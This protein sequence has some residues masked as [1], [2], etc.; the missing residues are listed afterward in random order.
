MTA[1]VQPAGTVTL[2]FTDI[3]G[4]TRLLEE[5][6][7]EGYRAALAEHRRI[8]REACSRY[9]GYEVDTEGDSFFYAFGSAQAAVGAVSDAMQGL[10]GGPVRVRV[11]IH[12]GEPA[13]DPPNYVGMDVHRAARIMSAAHGGQVVLS[14]STVALLEP[15]SFALEELGAHRLKDLS[16]P[17]VLYQLRVEGLAAVFPPLRTLH[18]S[19]LP[20]PTTPFRGRTDELAQVA[21]RLAHPDT[22]LLTLTGPGGTG[23]TRLALQAAAEAADSYPD[24]VIWVPLAPVRDA[25]LLIVAVAEALQLREQP[26]RTFVETIAQA[27]AGRRTLLLLDNV[28]HLLPSAARDVAGLLE[29]C[30]TLR[31]LVTSRERVRVRA[32]I[33]WSVPP[34]TASDGERLFVERAQAVGVEVGRDET[35]AALCRRLD[36]LPLAIELAAARTR[37]MSPAA[38][39]ARLEE[40]FDLLA[41]RDHDVD[42]RQRT[43]EAT[44]AWSYEL[45][46][47]DEQ[48]ALRALSVFVGGCTGDAAERVADAGVDLIESL[49]DRSL[50]RH[51]VDEGGRDRYWML[52]TI[53]EYAQ[54]QLAATTGESDAV[55][56][57]FLE[58]LRGVVGEVDE[59]WID[60]DQLEWFETLEAERANL[61]SGIAACRSRGRIEDGVR[62]VLAAFE[63]FD[64]RGP[65]APVV[66]LLPD[67]RVTDDRLRAQAFYARGV[68]AGRLGRIDEAKAELE[69]ALAV[70]SE[71]GDEAVAAKA[72]SMSASHRI[73]FG[74]GAPASQEPLMEEAVALA[75]RS[76]DRYSLAQ[77]LNG[78]G[79]VLASGV[80]VER[81]LHRFS[82]AALVA[83]EIGDQRNAAG[84]A[85][86]II[87]ACLSVR[88]AGEAAARARRAIPIM[89]R[90]RDANL[91]AAA[92]EQLAL[93]HVALGELDAARD[94]I[95]CVSVLAGERQFEPRF[96][97]ESLF[98]LAMAAAPTRRHDAVLLWSA[99]ER[100]RVAMSVS[101][102]EDLHPYVEEILEPLR[103]LEGFDD[104]WQAG[105]E[106]EL[107]A[108]LARGLQAPPPA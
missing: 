73:W 13:L 64:T 77:A 7:T 19:N 88:R 85:Y 33:T 98:V 106:L 58:W 22:R 100:A 45:L 86:N 54:R 67:A 10:A 68:L 41:T 1:V 39:V 97:V 30:P 37:A 14:P 78:L 95:A 65:W 59:Y 51:R 46:D 81:A 93:A 17:L 53:R 25:A 34:L 52:E 80:E 62:L 60:R 2:V 76:G 90:L 35:V 107:D 31:L 83:S 26:E 57:A 3:E 16:A 84:F 15:G 102:A 23:K 9:D 105:G 38:I 63:F 82:E 43:L 6:G 28:E 44:I 75:R 24:G 40:R 99:A 48:R 101:L 79:V 108:A 21:E 49:L 56:E 32:E 12:T 8:V 11:G 29:A 20:V 94:A 18:R 96:L 47:P 104:L 55:F 89:R 87:P 4:S 72:L 50:L 27:L 5:L 74:D 36:D 70:A 91:E 42:E 66:E 69:N 92:L 71:I 61:M 103:D